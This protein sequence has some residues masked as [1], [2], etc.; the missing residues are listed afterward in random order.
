MLVILQKSGRKIDKAA[1]C[2]ELLRLAGLVLLF[3]LAVLLTVLV[4]SA[5]GR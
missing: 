2:A 1:L 4:S 3:A 5:A